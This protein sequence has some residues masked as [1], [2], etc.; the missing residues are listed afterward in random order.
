MNLRKLKRKVITSIFILIIFFPII[1]GTIHLIKDRENSEN[2]KLAD[3]PVLD[4]KKL[5]N[6]PKKYNSYYKD[7][8]NFRNHLSYLYNLLNYKYQ[9]DKTPI[10]IGKDKWLF[11]KKT[12]LTQY[13]G[14]NKFSEKELKIFKKEIQRRERIVDSL[15]GKYYFVIA[16][17]KASVHREFLPNYVRNINPENNR[18]DQIVEILSSKPKNN[19]IDLRSILANKGKKEYLFFKNDNHWNSLGGYYAAEY[20]IN[21]LINDGINTSQVYPIHEYNFH[22]TEKFGGNLIN[23][24]GLGKEFKEET[25][26]M[27]PSE[28]IPEFIDLKNDKK[29]ESPKGFP[30]PWEYYYR[31]QSEAKNK[32]KTLIVRDSFTNNLKPFLSQCFKETTYIW[33]S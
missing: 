23:N 25:Y 21:R 31:D 3:K 15:G 6:F 4:F 12:V 20:I 16:P 30:Y 5:D 33:D 22:K 26:E 13:L 9:L 27:T 10:V 17:N 19:F 18:T 29:Y 14:K 8:F 1:N 7:N 2:R 28:K 32:I 24:L 11:T